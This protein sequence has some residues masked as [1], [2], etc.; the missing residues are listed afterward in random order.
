MS[1]KF[2]TSLGFLYQTSTCEAGGGLQILG[3]DTDAKL[4]DR[5]W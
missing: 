1:T 5:F 4:E 2:P 3:Q